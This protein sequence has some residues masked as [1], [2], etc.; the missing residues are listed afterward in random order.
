MIHEDEYCEP[1][2]FD[3]VPCAAWCGIPQHTVTIHKCRIFLDHLL[4]L[5]YI[6]STLNI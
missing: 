4:T 3:P 2:Y 1:R 5:C 6:L